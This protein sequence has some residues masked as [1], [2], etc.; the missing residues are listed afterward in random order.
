[1][2]LVI[3]IRL[4]MGAQQGDE[5]S[6]SAS[7][8][9]QMHLLYP[10]RRSISYVQFQIRTIRPEGTAFILLKRNFTDYFSE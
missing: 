7:D 4:G 1:M 8:M 3:I 10:G 9:D 2:C 5:P 6:N